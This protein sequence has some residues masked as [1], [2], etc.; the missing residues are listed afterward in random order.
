MRR[1]VLI[2]LLPLSLLLG[3]C[4]LGDRLRSGEDRINAVMPLS[5]QALQAHDRLMARLPEKS[6]ERAAAEQVWAERLQLRA[7]DC[8]QGF[9]PAWHH[10]NAQVRTRIASETCFAVFDRKLSAWAGLR[11][12]RQL[13]TMPSIAG[14]AKDAASPLTLPRGERG[15][16]GLDGQG[17]SSVLLMRSTDQVA[18]V[19]LGDGRTLHTHQS[20]QASV[21]SVSPNGRLFVERVADRVRRIHAT[22]GGEVLVELPHAQAISWLGSR[23]LAVT[24]PSADKYGYLLDLETAEEVL[25]PARLQASGYRFLPVP[26]NERRVNVLSS[27]SLEQFEVRSESGRTTASLVAEKP[28]TVGQR[29]GT[30]DVQEADGGKRWLTRLDSDLLLIDPVSLDLQRISMPPA[31]VRDASPSA[32]PG[33]YLVKLELGSSSTANGYYLLDAAARTLARVQGVEREQELRYF[34]AAGRYVAMGPDS[35]QVLGA[36]AAEAP[37]TL[38]SAMVALQKE[39]E[40]R[41]LNEAD[42]QMLALMQSASIP[43]D[44]PLFQ[45]MRSA[46]I[47]AVGVYEPRV[48]SSTPGKMDGSGPVDVIVRRSSRPLVLVLSSY[49]SVQW[50]L[51][52]EPGA[53]VEAVLHSG[54][55]DSTVVGAGTA[56]VLKI[57]TEYAYQGEG[58]AY[59]AL[60]RQVARWT[61]RSIQQFQGSYQGSNFSVGG[62]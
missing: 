44:S 12:V 8:G 41:K 38:D 20:S 31:F 1:L 60:Q 18:L 53:R 51:R 17:R 49:R 15:F 28:G 35:L 23:Y 2:P 32:E 59:Q 55:E 42:Q 52:L 21:E 45:Q 50:R 58:A 46:R 61:T 33:R 25:V 9:K 62:N 34:P 26:G 6:P 29:F 24:E 30:G 56:R 54:Y 37:R 16:A 3:G 10:S 5:A 47:E 14:A 19:A 4:D 39:S 13:L 48:F 40:N 43:A 36:L 7:R 27:T 22:E 57:G 11:R